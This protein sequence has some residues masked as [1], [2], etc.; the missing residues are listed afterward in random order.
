MPN[1]MKLMG[2]TS[3]LKAVDFVRLSRDM[4]V[5][6]YLFQGL[7]EPNEADLE[8]AMN[9]FLDALVL[10]T[11]MVCDA[12]GQPLTRS[13]KAQFA[14]HAKNMAL[15]LARFEKK[16]PKT[17]C[18]VLLHELLHVPHA[19]QRWNRVN[20]FWCFFGER[21]VGWMTYFV[22]QR[23]R[24]FASMWIGYSR[25]TFVRRIDVKTRDELH[26]RMLDKKVQLTPR[27]F[28]IPT[29]ELLAKKG[30]GRGAGRL[31]VTPNWRNSKLLD[32]LDPI[33]EE[34]CR[35]MEADS[36][37][38]IKCMT[39]G[40]ELDGVEWKSGDPALFLD[41]GEM[42]YGAVSEF[43]LWETDHFEDMLVFRMSTYKIESEVRGMI[44]VRTRSNGHGVLLHW[45]D[46]TH[47]CKEIPHIEGNEALKT[48]LRVVRTN[49]RSEV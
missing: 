11:S 37:A 36:N 21:Y 17:F 46:I 19:V 9:A 20:N 48:V 44:S 43:L 4:G 16:A 2:L 38:K 39:R 18:D 14:N 32:T 10:S 26:R 5:T 24:P 12:D 40:V 6:S 33:H 23:N 49:T 25:F 28:L 30:P 22:K 42:K 13:M 34:A 45:N 1:W 41:H 8:D 27:G 7:F 15:L 35:F 3:K 29:E 47:K 31:K